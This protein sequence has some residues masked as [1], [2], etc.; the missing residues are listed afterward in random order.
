MLMVACALVLGASCD[1]AP[2]TLS[3]VWI[4]F[5][6][7]RRVLLALNERNGEITGEGTITARPGR[8]EIDPS[9]RA[10]DQVTIQVSVLY[11]DGYS[12]GFINGV[13]RDDRIVGTMS[14]LAF[15]TASITLTRFP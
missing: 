2:Q 7:D 13:F 1:G 8:I 3:G 10:G 6:G 14:G 5:D 15:E 11:E 4:G 12:F 9:S